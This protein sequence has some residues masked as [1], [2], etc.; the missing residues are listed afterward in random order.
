M[1]TSSY[2]SSIQSRAYHK[3]IS[4]IVDN[5]YIQ[6]NSFAY[7][8]GDSNVE[9]PELQ[10]NVLDD[11][12]KRSVQLTYF[13]LNDT[14]APGGAASYETSANVRTMLQVSYMSGGSFYQVS[15]S[16]QRQLSSFSSL[17]SSGDIDKYTFIIQVP[18]IRRLQSMWGTQM[19]TLLRSYQI[20]IAQ[21]TRCSK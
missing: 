11:L 15:L 5:N 21:Q 8:I 9:D 13:T 12:A 1:K 17:P 18:N 19:D 2:R 4:A 20:A 14:I 10:P 3:A 7:V 6:P 16:F